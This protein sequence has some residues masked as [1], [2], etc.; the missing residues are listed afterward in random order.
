M[1]FFDWHF[2]RIV[3]A[4]RK[5]AARPEWDVLFVT[6]RAN[7]FDVDEFSEYK[8]EKIRSVHFAPSVDAVKALPQHFDIA[9]VCNN[10]AQE[11]I[12]L[13]AIRQQNNCDFVFV[14]AFDSHHSERQTL[15]IN[16]LADAVIPAHR[17][18]ASYMKSPTSVLGRH[19]PLSTSQWSRSRAA[20][21]FQSHLTLP[22]KNALHGKFVGHT[23]YGEDRTEFAQKLKATLPDNALELIPANIFAPY[24]SWSAEQRWL[25]WASHKVELVLPVRF[26]LPIRFFDSLLTGQ[27]PLV[28]EWCEDFD[29]VIPPALQA[30]LP[31]VRFSERSIEAVQAAWQK[32]L[33]LFDKDGIE[34]M[35]RRHLFALQHHHIT[36]RLESI[37]SQILPI[38]DA[39]DIRLDMDTKSVGFALPG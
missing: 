25:D 19:V 26:D 16:M 27:I 29:E 39:S 7:F 4:A 9:I 30:S 10:V 28:P 35:R 24:F 31:V 33:V 18:A 17:F 1:D 38:A 11:Q 14:W 15:S 34:G 13:F 32:A 22:R 6:H 36:N 2:E 5:V 23:V 20:Q 8:S 21:L 3:G 12:P 37:C